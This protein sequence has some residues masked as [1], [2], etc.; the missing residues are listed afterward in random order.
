MFEMFNICLCYY[1][2]GNWCDISSAGPT[3][4]VAA[5][6]QPIWFRCQTILTHGQPRN[7]LQ[8]LSDLHYKT[9]GVRKAVNQTTAG[10]MRFASSSSR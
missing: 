7:S 10:P 9:V 4:R 6:L 5:R 3:G 2:V 1:W 8:P